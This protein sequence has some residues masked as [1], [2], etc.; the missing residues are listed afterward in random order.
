MTFGSLFSGCGGFDLGFERGGLSC[1]W[2]CEIDPQA[3]SVLA[4]HWP[5]VT[6]FSD[7]REVKKKHLAPVD[8]IVGGFPCQGFS[9]AGRGGGLDDERSGLF[10]ELLRVVRLCRP[11]LV[12]WENVP[13]L[14]SNDRG[15]DFGRVLRGLAD[16]GYFGAWRVLDSQFFG[17]AQRR[18]R[19]F[20][21]FARGHRGAISCA[22]ILALIGGV[23]RHPAEGKEKGQEVAFTLTA[24]AGKRCGS[25]EGHSGNF[26]AGTLTARS[27]EKAGHNARDEAGLMAARCQTSRGQRNDAESDNLIAH[28]LTAAGFD[29]SED[30]T[31]RGS[32]LLAIR[33]SQTGANG[34]SQL[35]H[36]LGT[37]NGPCDIAPIAF[38][39]QQGG[40]TALGMS[41]EGEPPLRTN[42]DLA[43]QSEMGVR[44]MTPRE[45]ERLMTYPDDWTRFGADGEEFH[46][47]PRYRMCGNGVV[48]NVAE[49]LGRRLV[50]Y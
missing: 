45:W 13:G 40:D 8:V 50:R 2:Q 35:S 18:K 9:I 34:V 41:E 31:G 21:V 46:D 42:G 23:R 43:M 19:V 14:L 5:N 4:R 15:R 39:F 7:I 47:G 37:G 30:G 48:A 38:N 12:A 25:G 10:Y 33:T 16:C 27:K 49:W 26:I 11:R 3:S 36:T 6:R 22:E 29:A 44:R 20:G 24:S 1:S 32:P 17:S 28:T